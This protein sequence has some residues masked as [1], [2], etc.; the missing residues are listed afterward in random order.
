MVDL[1]YALSSEEHSP[2][3]LVEAYEDAADDPGPKYG[4]IAVCYAD[5]DAEARE[6]A[7]EWWPNAAVPGQL[8]QDLPTPVHF[9]QA[10]ALIDVHQVGPRQDRFFDG[11]EREILPAFV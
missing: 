5:S 9:E 7:A 8:S 11:Y 1:G 4:Q 2:A 3:S 10:T 6:T